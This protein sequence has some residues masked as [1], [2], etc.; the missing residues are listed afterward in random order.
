MEEV[1]VAAEKRVIEKVISEFSKKEN[2]KKLLEIT[3]SE[4]KK[5]DQRQKSVEITALE[6]W[7]LEKHLWPAK[8]KSLENKMR[9][10]TNEALNSFESICRHDLCDVENLIF[11]H[12]SI[13]VKIFDVLGPE[14]CCVWMASAPAKLSNQ[15]IE[16]A[17]QR[18][19]EL[20]NYEFCQLIGS[21]EALVQAVQKSVC[22][23]ALLLTRLDW[24]DE[25]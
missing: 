13:F 23:L 24:A 16:Y 14:Y 22:R 21:N 5:I 12:P 20:P 10:P 7:H 17:T 11:L 4:L 25:F 2:K 3:E 6:I 15:L 9:V 18:K 19:I 8:L 1:K